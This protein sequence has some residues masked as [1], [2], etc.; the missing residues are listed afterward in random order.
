VRQALVH[1]FLVSAVQGAEVWV[2]S[3]ELAQGKG[4]DDYLAGQ[5]RSNGQHEPRESL[6][7]LLATA[8]PFIETLKSTPWDLGLIVTELPKVLIPK[9]C[10]FSFVKLS[11]A[12]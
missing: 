1:T 8:K 5:F 10:A 11:P 4:I 12:V 6:G 9:S 7:T 2:M 3:W